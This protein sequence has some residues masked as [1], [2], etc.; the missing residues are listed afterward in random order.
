LCVFGNRYAT[1]A[2]EGMTVSGSRL[3]LLSSS[4]VVGTVLSRRRDVGR[5][6]SL[7]LVGYL[8]GA[9]GRRINLKELYFGPQP[10]TE[11][12]LEVIV[13]AGTGMSTGKTTVMR[14][15]LRALAS[16]GMAVAGCKLT[17]TASPR[18]LFEMRATGALRLL[19][20]LHLRGIRRGAARTV[21]PH[22]GPVPEEGRST[23][24]RR[25]R[26]RRSAA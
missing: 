5:P 24:G 23:G 21:R 14:K 13:V 22:V 25:N 10:E 15:A 7:T 2:Y 12:A 1:D 8:R 20:S 19:I 11:P 3:H 18:D 9:D 4:G 16:R 17:G 6:T 26:R